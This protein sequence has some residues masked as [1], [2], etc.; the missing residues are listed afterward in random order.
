MIYLDYNA[1]TPVASEVAEV[2]LPYIREE[3]G[4]PS[5]DY[6]LGQRAREAVAQARREVAGLLGGQPEEIVF[7][8]CATEANNAVLKGVA[9]QFG[10][11]HIIASAV[12]HPAVT[13][14]LSYL[15]TEGFEVSIVPVDGR[16]LVDPDDVERAAERI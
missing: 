12:E 6:P 8:G 5:S 9:W 7:A 16:G 10:K 4:N 3:F 11:G 13:Q 14:P 1:T 2:M 15:L